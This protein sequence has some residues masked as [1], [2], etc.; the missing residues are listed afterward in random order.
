MAQFHV[1]SMFVSIR[2]RAA[3]I[4]VVGENLRKQKVGGK[5]RR[6]TLNLDKL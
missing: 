3:D 2:G 1:D 5:R 6:L 4:A